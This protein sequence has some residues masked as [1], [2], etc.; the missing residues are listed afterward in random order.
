M[1]LERSNN[2]KGFFVFI[3]FFLFFTA[4]SDICF[5]DDNNKQN[6]HFVIGNLFSEKGELKNAIKE[7]KKALELEPDS[8]RIL[9]NIGF[10]FYRLGEFEK[11][12]TY[13]KKAVEK[14]PEYST[15]YNNMGVVK[16]KKED[17]DEQVDNYKKAV[18][19]K[20]DCAKYRSNLAVAYYHK[21][22]YWKAFTTI[23][24]AYRLDPGYIGKRFNEKE[25][26]EAFEKALDED[27]DNPEL[28][29]IKAWYDSYRKRQ[30]DFYKSRVSVDADK[31]DKKGE[32][33][34]YE[35][36]F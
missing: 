22:S 27:P 29:R 14:D 2:A 1:K 10:M 8:S 21:K 16:G 34:I 17:I 32:I 9:N 36:F 11:A 12:E 20:P 3:V 13:Y 26:H 18:H 33:K 30:S 6:H 23:I 28:K 5:S 4:L 15:A 19:Y 25:V 24:K 31:K 35:M 7:Y